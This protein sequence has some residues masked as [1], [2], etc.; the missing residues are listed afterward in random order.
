MSKSQPQKRDIMY[1]IP[2]WDDLVDL[3]YDFINDTPTDGLKVTSHEIYGTAPYDGILVSK[4]KIEENKKNLRRVQKSGIHEHL[5][6]K[7]PVFGDCGAYGYINDRDPPFSPVEIADY[8]NALGFD[9]GVSVDH[10][11]VPAVEDEKQYRF[12]LTMKNAES[13]L[14]RHQERAYSYVPIGA[15]QGW[16]PSSYQDAVKALLDMGYKYI[17]I[18]GLTRAQTSNI[19]KVMRAVH[20]VIEKHDDDIK[21]HLFG[22]ARI[23]ALRTLQELGLSS[24]DSASHLRRSWLGARS[25]YILSGDKGYAAL[26][27]PQ[28][29]KSPRAKKIV[30]AGKIEYEELAAYER[31]CM[32]LLRAFDRGDADIDEVLEALLWYDRLMGDTRDHADLYKKTLE[33]KPWKQCDCA[34]C[35]QIGIEV[36]IFRGNNR[37]RRRGFHNTYVFYNELKRILQE[38]PSTSQATLEDF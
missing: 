22:V 6:F 35:K 15:A 19:L 31:G 28:S 30:E 18:G 36:I 7:G 23:N 16:N 14:K 24:F 11:I 1:F 2:W 26:R 9:Y 33:D 10:L 38:E 34:I 5:N 12:D 27:V 17:A 13:F 29:D 25:N 37:N 3:N 21:V 20:D 8:Y 32:T 4:V